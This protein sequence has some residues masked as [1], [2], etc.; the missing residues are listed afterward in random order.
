MNDVASVNLDGRAVRRQLALED[1][2]SAVELLELQNGCVCCGP[3]AGELAGQVKALAAGGSFDHVVIELSGVADPCGRGYSAKRSRG[4][5]A[6]AAWIF[7]E[8]KSRRRRGCHVDI[9]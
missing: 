6:A 4:G 9:P 5:A 8:E 3:S 2:D 7:R 1:D